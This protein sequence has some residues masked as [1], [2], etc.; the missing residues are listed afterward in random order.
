MGNIGFT[1]EG[2]ED[3]AYWQ[4]EDKRMVKKINA[5]LRDINRNGLSEG[6]GKPEPLEQTYY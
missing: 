1:E 6:I 5:L 3:Y 4:A 2:F